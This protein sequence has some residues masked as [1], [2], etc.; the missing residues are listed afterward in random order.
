MRY[1]EYKENIV[2]GSAKFPFA[3]YFVNHYHPRYRMVVHWHKECEIIRIISG[4]FQIKI[5][6]VLYTAK[7]GD[8]LFLNSGC[9]HSGIPES[10]VYECVVFDISSLLQKNPLGNTELNAIVENKKE[11]QSL[12]TKENQEAY[13]V[14]NHIFDLMKSKKGGY[15]LCIY[16]SLYYF[17]GIVEELDLYVKEKAFAAANKKVLA[18]MKKVLSLIEMRYMEEI[19]LE[20]MAESVNM[21]EKYFCK[22]FKEMTKKTPIEYL[23]WY[24]I[25][26]A[27]EKIKFSA[28][29][30]TDIAYD[31]GFND[32]S[33]FTKVFRKYNGLTPREYQKLYNS[34]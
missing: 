27:C 28:S 4:T 31:C 26:C 10:C 17:L 14:L 16:G 32:T 5:N 12:Y 11:I 15:Q 8:I 21:N 3:Y 19:G 13:D 2:H 25:E 1:F 22:F 30:L 18:Q 23:N 34:N 29:S 33:Y 20:D 24:R 7:E 9:I 6:M